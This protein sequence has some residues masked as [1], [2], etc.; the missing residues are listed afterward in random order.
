MSK[1][2]DPPK[3]PVGSKVAAKDPRTLQFAPTLAYAIVVEY[4]GNDRYRVEHGNGRKI[5]SNLH[6]DELQLL[7]TSST[8]KRECTCSS[9]DLFRVGCK[10]GGFILSE[11]KS[12]GKE[13]AGYWK[14]HIEQA[15]PEPEKKPEEVNKKEAKAESK[16]ISEDEDDYGYY[17]F[18][19]QL[20]STD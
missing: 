17:L 12:T 1:R 20:D 7:E 14:R 9:W 13:E 2:Y 19:M 16:K 11:E 3:Y 4:C 5:I 18:G 6:A 8:W 15:Q 10:C